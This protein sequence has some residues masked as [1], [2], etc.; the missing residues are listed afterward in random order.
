M[1]KKIANFSFD[2]RGWGKLRQH[3]ANE[4]RTGQ[5]GTQLIE[6]NLTGSRVKSYADVQH[7]T[8]ILHSFEEIRII[9]LR[10]CGL[11]S[12]SFLG[13]VLC[14]K[15]LGCKCVDISG[16]E[17]SKER[18]QDLINC[19]EG[20]SHTKDVAP[21]FLALGSNKHMDELLTPW[22]ASC[23]PFAKYGCLC[24]SRR[25]V[26]VLVTLQ[27]PPLQSVSVAKTRPQLPAPPT[28]PPPSPPEDVIKHALALGQ[29]R[30]ALAAAIGSE[31]QRGHVVVLDAVE[32]VLMKTLQGCFVLVN[33]DSVDTSAGRV[34]DVAGSRVKLDDLAILDDGC[35]ISARTQPFA[36]G[37]DCPSPDVYLRTAGQEMI[38]FCLESAVEHDWV[39]ARRVD[40]SD[41]LWFP[42]SQ[43]SSP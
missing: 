1:A 17:V 29:A 38:E 21:F 2:A 13:E 4:I 43:C 12:L 10:G 25:V 39:A 28:E 35:I 31:R 40:S 5:L 27:R 15:L 14:Q 8:Q 23:D 36:V 30:D 24:R 32:Y 37:E 34:A 19:L 42:L 20:R 41:W 18:V 16:N 9:N 3:V 6:L 22:S 11:T 33:L 26:H 7:L